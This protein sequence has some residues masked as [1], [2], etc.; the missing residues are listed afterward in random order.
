M[1]EKAQRMR[2]A[3]GL[4][5]ALCTVVL[6]GQALAATGTV[7][8][9]SM[10]HTA[11]PG[12]RVS[13]T[14]AVSP[15]KATCRLT[16][17]YPGAPAQASLALHKTRSGRLTWQWA[18]PAGTKV[19][20]A[21]VT[22][23]CAG[24]GVKTRTLAIVAVAQTVKIS[25]V[26]SGYTIR[27]RSTGGADVSYGLLL[28]NE[29]ATDD[30]SSVSVLVNFVMADGKLLG[31]AS[32]VVT[33]IPAGAVYAF[34]ADVNFPGAAPITK[35][36]VVTTVGRHE[37]HTPVHIPALANVGLEP[38]Q[39]DPGY[40]GKVVGE[41]V[42]DDPTLVLRSATVSAV[43]LDAA[44][45]ILGGGQGSVFAPLQP[46]TREVFNIV[47]GV[48]PIPWPSAASSIVSVTPNYI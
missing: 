22:A 48:T 30:A 19:G 27:N 21:L 45:N 10:P 13:A 14:I 3:L 47:S 15:K 41:V 28:Q 29:S 2:L 38:G 24:A 42:N 33:T 31:S 8:F 39:F 46:G 17:R 44:G 4:G 34:G 16:I 36:E 1:L 6:A 23:N 25:V 7:R 20:L 43:V 37:T 40:V 5:A 11:S 32:R 26:K 18:I 9:V 12:G 35:L